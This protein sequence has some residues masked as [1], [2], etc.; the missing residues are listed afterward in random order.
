MN[1][2]QKIKQFSYSQNISNTIDIIQNKTIADFSNKL[3][4]HILSEQLLHTTI[5]KHR[6]NTRL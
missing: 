2:L 5:T 1:S 4:K 3:E 6:F